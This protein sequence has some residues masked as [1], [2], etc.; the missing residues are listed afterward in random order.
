KARLFAM[1][2]LEFA[3][4]NRDDAFGAQ[5]IDSLRAR[6]PVLDFSLLGNSLPGNTG[7]QNA[8]AIAIKS[9]EFHA[10]GVSAARQPIGKR[11]P[12]KSG[13]ARYQKFHSVM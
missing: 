2:D 1:P 7:A 6:L 13:S 9:A 12:Q 3:V 4:I 11:R 5:L 10:H 8:A